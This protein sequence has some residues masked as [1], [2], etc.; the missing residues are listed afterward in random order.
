MF[1]KEPKMASCKAYALLTVKVKGSHQWLLRTPGLRGRLY[2]RAIS[3]GLRLS[4]A[5]EGDVLQAP[6]LE[7]LSHRLVP[8]LRCQG[9]RQRFWL[10]Q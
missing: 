6:L 1:R 7:A 3:L 10:Y 5:H 9:Q 8:P 2:R 4:Y